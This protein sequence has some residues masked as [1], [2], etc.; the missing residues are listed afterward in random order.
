MLRIRVRDPVP[1]WPLNPGIGIFFPNPDLWYRIP[2]TYFWKLSDNSLGKSTGTK[3]LREFGSNFFF[4]LFTNKISFNFVIF[5]ATKRGRTTNFF[6]PPLFLLPFLD[7]GIRDWDPGFLSRILDPAA[8]TVHVPLFSFLLLDKAYQYS[9]TSPAVPFGA[10][11][12][13]WIEI[14]D[15]LFGPTRLI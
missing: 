3:I 4:Y 7:P 6:P 12:V 2:N 10:W 9:M 15:K 8:L 14:L 13:H 5:V 1:F 11:K